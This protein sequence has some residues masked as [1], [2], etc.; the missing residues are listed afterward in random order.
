MADD[1]ETSESTETT[2]DTE[3][4]TLEAEDTETDSEDALD[5]SGLL[6]DWETVMGLSGIDGEAGTDD[7]LLLQSAQEAAER[8]LGRALAVN[9]FVVRGK[10]SQGRILLEREP[11]VEVTRVLN[12]W[13]QKEIADSCLLV[14]NGLYVTD[15]SL[16]GAVCMVWYTAG[17][18]K[19]SLPARLKECLVRIYLQKKRAMFESADGS[20]G[21]E[22]ECELPGDVSEILGSYRG[23]NW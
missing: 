14:G 12:L 5:W 16:E 4:T 19:E 3:E 18:T 13:T 21:K 1:E 15:I 17:W 23:V 2:S 8:F 10:I 20:A 6:V 7:L 11:V 22:T 9:E